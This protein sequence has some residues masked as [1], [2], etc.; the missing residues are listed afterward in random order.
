MSRNNTS[1]NTALLL[2]AL[3]AQES[4]TE[5]PPWNEDDSFHES[6][7]ASSIEDNISTAATNHH[8]GVYMKSLNDAALRFGIRYHSTVP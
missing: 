8:T 6:E 2:L 5:Y 3:D 1:A 7:I 4:L